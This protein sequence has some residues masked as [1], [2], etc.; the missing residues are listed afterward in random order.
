MSVRQSARFA[1]RG[2]SANKLRSML[3]T[4]GILIG[5]AA[6]IVLVAVGTGSSKSVADS[7]SALG[8]NVLSVSPS[9]GGTG[10]RAGGFGGFG[11]FGGGTRVSTGSQTR[12]ATLTL[13]DAAALTDATEAPDVLSVAPV[14]TASSVTATYDGATHSVSSFIGTSPSYLR[15]DNDSVQAG[16]AFSDSDFT[17]RRRVALLGTDVAKDLVGGTGLDAVGKTV[18]FDGAQWTV[19]GILTDKGSTGPTSLDDRVIAPLPAVQD[20]LSGY[21]SLSSISVKAASADSVDEAESE[22]TEILRGRHHVSSTNADFTI[23]SSSSILTAATSSNKTFTV[24]LASVAAI[25]LLV[26]GIGVMNIM[27]VTVTERTRE[28]GIR[29]A[30][31]ARRGDIVGQFLIEAV[32]LSLFGAIAGVAVG[33]LG[34][35]FTIVG[36]HP[37]VAPY[38]VALAFGVAVATGLVFGLY[39]AN[40]AASLR[41]ID[42]LR[43][44]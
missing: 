13:E 2:V 27:L 12:T 28:I 14:V 30:T 5:V 4:L 31:G 26:G 17:Q 18:E 36:V 39:P 33:L 7:I 16:S 23:R 37:V 34:S 10:G 3:T 9:Q 1:V 19:V 25:S 20:T 8:S 35:R 29:K 44:E 24:L 40:R 22:V 21:G 6:V 38:S 41:P 11:G 42:A 43:Y 32:L 15:N